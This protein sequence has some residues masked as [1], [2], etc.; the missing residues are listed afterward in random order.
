MTTEQ[1]QIRRELM[2]TMPGG[3][4]LAGLVLLDTLKESQRLLAGMADMIR[5]TNERMAALEQAVRTLEKVTPAQ[6]ARINQ[7][8]RKRAAEICREYLAEGGEKEAA[9]AIRRR[10]REMTGARSAREIARVDY[11]AAL[12]LA[13]SWDDYQAMRT[14]KRRGRP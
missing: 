3:E 7:A 14:I 12:S 6:A 13:E 2:A 4:R 8:V 1:E 9:A 10:L 11:E 5:L